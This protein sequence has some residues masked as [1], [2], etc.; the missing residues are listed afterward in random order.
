MIDG[1]K[2]YLK[3]DGTFRKEQKVKIGNQDYFIINEGPYLV[4]EISRFRMF[5]RNL[6]HLKNPRGGFEYETKGK[7]R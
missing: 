6:F 4:K 7:K 3:P 1:M 5:L 2:T